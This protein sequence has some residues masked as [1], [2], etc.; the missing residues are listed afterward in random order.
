MQNAKNIKGYY[1]M[2][3]EISWG[4]GDKFTIQFVDSGKL[5]AGGKSKQK[6]YR[7]SRK[8]RITHMKELLQKGT[9]LRK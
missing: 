9:V 5:M 8:N 7:W 4:G 3:S 1:L 6:H 2:T